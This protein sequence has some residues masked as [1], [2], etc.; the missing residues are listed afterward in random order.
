[1]PVEMKA[2][3]NKGS[4]FEAQKLD[5]K[6]LLFDLYLI[7]N[8]SDIGLREI[9]PERIKLYTQWKQ[10]IVKQENTSDLEK[11]VVIL[12]N[13]IPTNVGANSNSPI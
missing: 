7:R 10:W 1:M 9:N 6:T 13:L 3:L 4:L 5:F 11:L 12:C 8:G 2:T